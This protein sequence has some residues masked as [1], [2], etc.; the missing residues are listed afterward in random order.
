MEYLNTGD[1]PWEVD[2]EACIEDCGR[3]QETCGDGEG[4]EARTGGGIVIWEDGVLTIN[5]RCL[6]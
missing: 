1:E 3:I 2:Y 5:V 6:E 4:S